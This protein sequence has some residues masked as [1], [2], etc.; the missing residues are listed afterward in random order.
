MISRGSRGRGGGRA[1][2]DPARRRLRL[3]R[4][5]ADRA[6]RRVGRRRR[7]RG[8]TPSSSAT[9]RSRS[10]RSGRLPPGEQ[11]ARAAVDGALHDLQGKLTGRPVYSLLGL[12]RAGPADLVDGLARRPR[13]HGAARREGRQPRLPAAEAE[14]RRPR[15]PRPRARPRGA[16]ASP[17]CRCRCDVNE[18]WSLDEALE[19][20]PQ[21]ELE[22][23]EQPLPAGD[24]GGPE[25]KRRSPVPIYVDEDCHTLADVAA[26]AE[27]AHGIN[28]K[29]AKSG[30]IREAVRMVERSARARARRDARLHGRVGPRDRRR[31]AH[32]E[33]DGPRRPRRQPV[34]RD[35]PWPG[36]AFVDGVQLPADQP[37]LGV[38]PA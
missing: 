17:T 36:V 4:G 25:L 20:L 5:G 35:D 18:Y 7:S 21:M 33:P 34:A 11:A 22:Y 37:G 26:C 8:S 1:G 2:R 29:L 27:R 14:A 9:T 3:R 15:R 28:I 30:G 12:R 19:Y 13:R 16:R 24:P 32:R 10:T 23:C 31:R 38:A 6:L